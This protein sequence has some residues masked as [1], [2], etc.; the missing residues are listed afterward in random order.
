SGIRAKIDVGQLT[1]SALL[2]PIRF[3]S[4]ALR[5][6]YNAVVR[7]N[8]AL[9]GFQFAK[10]SLL[11]YD[12]IYISEGALPQCAQKRAVEHERERAAA[13]ALRERALPVANGFCC[14]EPGKEAAALP[15]LPADAAAPI[16]ALRT[17]DALGQEMR[18]QMLPPRP[19]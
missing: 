17:A 3:W 16:P 8:I 10:G 18:A 15:E 1:A 2:E 11:E 14:T 9:A 12:N 4:D 13:L 5:Q 6:E 19:L 7:Y